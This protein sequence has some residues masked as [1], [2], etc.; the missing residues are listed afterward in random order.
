MEQQIAALNQEIEQAGILRA[1][2]TRLHGQLTAGEEPE[3]ATWLTTMELMNMYDKYFSKDELERLPFYSNKSSC[4]SNGARW[5][6][7]CR[8]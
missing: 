7:A 3:L 2:L 4:H 1:Q 5:W 6:R 8:R